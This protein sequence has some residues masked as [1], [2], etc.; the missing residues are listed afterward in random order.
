MLVMVIT[1]S[2]SLHG[3][4]DHFNHH[5][6]HTTLFHL[7]QDEIEHF[8]FLVNLTSNRGLF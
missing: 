7:M 5:I 8:N 6:R 4:I 1:Y 2:F 3:F